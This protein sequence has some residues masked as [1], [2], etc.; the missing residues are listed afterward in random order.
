M[1][2]SS[3][4]RR[5]PHRALVTVLLAAV[6]AILLGVASTHA[7]DA[8]ACPSGFWG[9]GCADVCPVQ[10]R[11]GGQCAL[12]D[13]GHGNL[14]SATD[15]VC[16]CPN[17][18]YASPLCAVC[19]AGYWGEGCLDVCPKAC[20]NGG[21][22]ELAGDDHGNLDVASEVTCRCPAGFDGPLCN[23][24]LAEVA[25]AAPEDPDDDDDED[26]QTVAAAAPGSGTVAPLT[27]AAIA[28][29]AV[30]SLVGLGLIAVAARRAVATSNKRRAEDGGGDAAAAVD[31]RGGQDG[32]ASPEEWA[33]P[34]AALPRREESFVEP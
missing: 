19:K 8:V 17:D 9:E 33:T 26:H 10:C 14:E 15:I 3:Q 7:Q 11:N 5:P 25:A 29:I 21:Y 28:G 12:R 24:D 18:N 31:D 23:I 22:C 16:R 20:E 13:D 34:A 4:R 1:V 27:A 32:S 30:G 2:P 6:N